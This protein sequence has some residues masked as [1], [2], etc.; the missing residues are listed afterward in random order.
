M[1]FR[2]VLFRS[3][4]APLRQAALPCK[5]GGPCLL[6]GP[7]FKGGP[8]MTETPC[9]TVLKCQG[10]SYTS[11]AIVFFFPSERN[12]AALAQ[13]LRDFDQ[14]TMGAV[15]A[16]QHGAHPARIA[17]GESAAVTRPYPHRD[18]RGAP[19]PACRH[20]PS[21]PARAVGPLSKNPFGF[22]M[23][24]SGPGCVKT[25]F[26]FQELHLPGRV[27]RRG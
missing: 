22:W 11:T 12:D 27:G 8:L 18:C 5:L 7:S 13:K 21:I 24:A 14:N 17:K 19:G 4:K 3:V 2:R 20:D 9:P 15:P 10:S 26:I 23:S 25:F 1:E 6:G 16:R